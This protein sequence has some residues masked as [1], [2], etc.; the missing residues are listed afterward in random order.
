MIADGLQ[1]RVAAVSQRLHG[2]LVLRLD[3]RFK[4]HL[5]LELN[6]CDGVAGGPALRHVE[7]T[8]FELERVS[9]RLASVRGSY[10]FDAL[11]VVPA[12]ALL[13]ARLARQSADEAPLV[14]YPVHHFRL[15]TDQG[16]C[17]FLAHDFACCDLYGRAYG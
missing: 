12:S 5:K 3:L 4:H 15:R 7:L 17:D 9:T 2:A 16:D 1:A 10:A 13:E 6:V 14:T 11:T 8:F